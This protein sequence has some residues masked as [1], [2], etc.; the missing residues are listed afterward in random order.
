[1]CCSAVI[2]TPPTV[3]AQ[4]KLK[5]A[6]QDCLQV[7][8]Q[9][10]SEPADELASYQPEGTGRGSASIP[11]VSSPQRSTESPVVVHASSHDGSS[12]SPLRSSHT[13][14]HPI[15][16]PPC[17]PRHLVPHPWLSSCPCRQHPALPNHP[18][19]HSLTAPC[20][21]GMMGG[22]GRQMGGHPCPPSP[23]PPPP[24]RSPPFCLQ[25]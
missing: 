9:H 19:I 8:H 25:G 12:T 10:S 1:M 21:L 18:L 3:V 13:H 23:P 17:P 20:P 22:H 11:S 6:C 14:Y 24:P 16:T 7:L 2:N 15:P 4:A 5:C